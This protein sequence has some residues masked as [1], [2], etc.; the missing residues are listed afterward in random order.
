M[1]RTAVVLFS[2]SQIIPGSGIRVIEL[3]KNIT[4]VKTKSNETTEKTIVLDDNSIKAT[5]PEQ[6]IASGGKWIKIDLDYDHKKR[7]FQQF[8][9]YQG[10]KVF[11]SGLASGAVTNVFMPRYRH[12]KSP[13][14]HIGWFWV[15]VRAQ[16]YMSK[17]YD[18]PM[19]YC[20]FYWNGH[21][22]HACQ[23]GDI[24]RLGRPA[25]HGCTRVSPSNAKKL[26]KWAGED[27]VLVEIIR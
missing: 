10:Q 4:S 24:R 1:L 20:L 26:Y 18:V 3:S 14:N 27:P 15:G 16:K 6:Y 7:K 25:S 5:S 11:L 21:A 22:V 17:E 13:H 23:N 8:T 2:L 9:A 19:R 12:P